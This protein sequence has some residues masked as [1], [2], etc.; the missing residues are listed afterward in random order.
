MWQYYEDCRATFRSQSNNMSRLSISEYGST[1]SWVDLVVT[2]APS[3]QE[4]FT[5]QRKVANLSEWGF[6]S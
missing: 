1:E 3:V 5:S 2:K 4:F 6:A